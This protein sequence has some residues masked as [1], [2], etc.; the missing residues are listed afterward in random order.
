MISDIIFSSRITSRPR[1]LQPLATLYKSESL[2]SDDPSVVHGITSLDT[3][4]VRQ[5]PDIQ[6]LRGT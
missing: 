3:P 2:I 4:R 5:G 1:E 6:N